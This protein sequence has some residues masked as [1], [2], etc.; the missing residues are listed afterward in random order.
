MDALSVMSSAVHVE[1]ERRAMQLTVPIQAHSGASRKFG[2][3]TLLGGAS[4]GDR[5]WCRCVWHRVERTRCVVGVRLV[6]AGVPSSN[7]CFSCLQYRGQLKTLRKRP[8]FRPLLGDDRRDRLTF[9]KPL[10]W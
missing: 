7:D 2:A 9:S 1:A 6:H 8:V 3:F 4:G 5:V 10:L